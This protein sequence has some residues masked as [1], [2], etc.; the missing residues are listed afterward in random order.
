[1]DRHNLS[2]RS[3]FQGESVHECVQ[4]F[5]RDKYGSDVDV[6]DSDLV[7]ESEIEG[8]KINVYESTF[9]LSNGTVIKSIGH[10]NTAMNEEDGFLTKLKKKLIGGGDDYGPVVTKIRVVE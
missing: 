2:D 3:V 8:G 1:M 6:L 4:T 10:V 7:E 9:E 5:I